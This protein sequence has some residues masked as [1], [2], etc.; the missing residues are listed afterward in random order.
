MST[1][2]GLLLFSG[3][4]A[5]SLPAQNDEGV[6]NGRTSQRGEV[7]NSV[8]LAPGS[9]RITIPF[10]DDR[11]ATIAVD[12][13]IQNGSKDARRVFV[14]IVVKD[15]EGNVVTEAEAGVEIAAGE[16]GSTEQWLNLKRPKYWT[17]EN[18][19]LYTVH[20]AVL[21]E[22]DIVDS[23]ESSFGVGSAA[24]TGK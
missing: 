3:T 22:S 12:I 7:T 20:T 1:L 14:E 18:P 23:S 6:S 13:A 2:S 17:P 8:R 5:L 21:L 19:Y 4:L 16:T 11:R 9:P 15:A 24:P 10:Y